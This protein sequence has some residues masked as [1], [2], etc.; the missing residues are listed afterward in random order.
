MYNCINHIVINIIRV[1]MTAPDCRL[2]SLSSSLKWSSG[3]LKKKIGIQEN[4]HF[5]FVTQKHCMTQK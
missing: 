5:F 3:N 2:W 1:P 4:K